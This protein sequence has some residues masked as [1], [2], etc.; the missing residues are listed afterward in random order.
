[1]SATVRELAALVQGQVLGDED[2]VIQAAR[3]LT[4]AGVGDITFVE[5]AK[6][7][8]CLPG[9]QAS[10]VVAPPAI[11]AN[12]LTMIR[13]PD[14]L[15]AFVAI[16]RYLHGH[17]EDPPHG[18]DPRAHVHPGV[19]IGPEASLFPFVAVGEGTVVGERCRLHSGVTIGKHCRLGDDVVLFPNVVLYDGTILGNRVIIHANSVIGA[20]GF[21]YRQHNGRHVKVPQ[22]GH[23]EIGDDVEIGACTTIDRGT[24]KATRVGEG[25][26]VDNL[27]QVGHNCRIGRH[28]L[29]VSQVGIGGSSTTG[30]YVV[31]AGQVGIVDH[32]HIGD[33]VVIGGQAGVT[34]DVAPG[35]RVLGTPANPEGL[36]KRIFMSLEKLPDL[37]RDVR[38]LQQ[39][40]GLSSSEG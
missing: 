26:K 38:R 11:Q 30:D 34:R 28:N 14:P 6:H 32:I 22:L 4:E 12:G 19:H 10:A 37:R 8:A 13:V 36:Q 17:P 39:H 3:P 31:A 20:D 24:F 25:T 23:V 29:L 27:V 35:Q 1:M 40:L 21:G 2:L 33:H 7:A 9:H 15:T 16:V 18:I 5:D